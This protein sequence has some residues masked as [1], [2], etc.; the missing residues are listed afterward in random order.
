MSGSVMEKAYQLGKKYEQ[1]Y[2]GCSQCVIAALQD[3]F[4]IRNEDVFKAATGLGRWGRL[5]HR[6]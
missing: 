3:A 4:N 5:V 2:K 6:W 1:T